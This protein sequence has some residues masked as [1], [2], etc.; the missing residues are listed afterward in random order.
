MRTLWRTHPGIE[1]DPAPQAWICAC[2][3]CAATTACGS[4]S[5]SRGGWW[6]PLDQ[7]AERS[8]LSRRSYLRQFAKATGTTPIKWLIGQRVQASLELLESSDLSIGQIAARVGSESAV[9]YRRHFVRQIHTT[10]R[11]YRSAFTGS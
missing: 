2:T 5:A 6:Y 11:D 1:I 8:A 4:P 7:L 10:L 9:T 3:S